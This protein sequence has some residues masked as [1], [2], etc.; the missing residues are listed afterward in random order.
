M[1]GNNQVTVPAELAKEMEL[2]PGTRFDWIR[3]S[4][5][6][7]ILIEVKPSKRQMLKRVQEIGKSCKRNLIKELIEGRERDE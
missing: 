4:T 5:P 2:E 7:T 1:T 3:G 6:G